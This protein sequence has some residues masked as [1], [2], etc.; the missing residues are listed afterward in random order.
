MIEGNELSDLHLAI[1]WNFDR[2]LAHMTDIK[3]HFRASEV[4]LTLLDEGIINPELIDINSF[5]KIILEG[6][7]AFPTL[8]F[9]IEINLINL[10]RI[11]KTLKVQKIGHMN[12]IMV[13]PPY[14]P[15]RL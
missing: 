3:V 6:Q 15:S 11:V 8:D 13:I 12:Y 4:S 7:G 9:P 2:L 14:E 10:P 1:E 5:K